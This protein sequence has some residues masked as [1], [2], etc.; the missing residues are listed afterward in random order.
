MGQEFH[1]GCSSWT[2]PAWTGRFYPAGLPDRDRLPFYAQYFDTVEVDSTYYTPP[3]AFVVQSWAR[4]TPDEFRF[5]LKFPRDLLDPKKPSGP[6]ELGSFVRTA[7]ELG[8]KLGPILLQFPPWFR[9]GRSPREGFS[10]YLEQVLEALPE[11]PRFAVELRD[12]RWYADATG[13]W[14]RELLTRR[15]IASCWS[16]LNYVDIPP[17]VTT[18]WLYVRFIGDHETVPAEQHGELRVDKTD[19]LR[20]W[21][22]RL[23]GVKVWDAWFLFNNHYAG[24]APASAN[25]LRKEL[26]LDP[27]V[28]PS[29]E[30][31]RPGTTLDDV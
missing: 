7:Q 10:A 27:I 4:K 14:L 30:P 3:R 25:L 5:S 24:Y 2:S 17:W 23:A 15:R 8:P 31:S 9:P 19:D 16:S 11:G 20:M 18:D 28:L 29:A 21:T 1:I 13:E 12:R 26:G 6:A 22:R